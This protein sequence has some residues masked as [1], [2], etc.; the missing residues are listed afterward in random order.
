MAV[1]QLDQLRNRTALLK[2]CHHVLPLLHNK[3]CPS[4]GY[5]SLVLATNSNI[6]HISVCSPH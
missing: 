6:G 1:K 5:S 4:T 3:W 2:V